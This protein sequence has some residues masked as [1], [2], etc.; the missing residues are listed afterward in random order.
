LFLGFS[1]GT[2]YKL[3]KILNNASGLV[4]CQPQ[5]DDWKNY[6]TLNYQTLDV[7]LA[8]LTPT[9]D[10]QQVGVATGQTLTIGQ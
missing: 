8:T 4:C 1:S 7:R 3:A 10:K 2:G 6:Q 5:V 9:G